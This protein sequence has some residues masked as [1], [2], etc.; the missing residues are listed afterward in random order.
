MDQEFFVMCFKSLDD[1]SIHKLSLAC[2][3]ERKDNNGRDMQL[4]Y[5][6]IAHLM[7]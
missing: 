3:V 2:C 6:K 5:Q 4:V 1:P 7:T